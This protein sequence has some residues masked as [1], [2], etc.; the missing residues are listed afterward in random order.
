MQGEK[1]YIYI[2]CVISPPAMKLPVRGGTKSFFISPDNSSPVIQ[3]FV[4][5]LLGELETT[6]A[7]TFGQPLFHSWCTVMNPICVQSL[8]HRATCY[9]EL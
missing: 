6:L 8:S 7:M 1:G 4:D 5:M 9:W 3:I 2:P